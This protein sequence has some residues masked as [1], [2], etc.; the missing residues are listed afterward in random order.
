[1]I[2]PPGLTARRSTLVTRSPRPSL[3]LRRRPPPRG[4]N[5]RV[6]GSIPTGLTIRSTLSTRAVPH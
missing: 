4:W 1:M 2:L 3:A 5:Q 6:V